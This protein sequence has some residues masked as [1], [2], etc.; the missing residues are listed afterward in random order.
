MFT[1]EHK[2]FFIFYSTVQGKCESKNITLLLY[3]GHIY[4]GY[5]KTKKFI[6]LGY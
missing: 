2:T 4:K 5:K 6:L 3:K 1:F